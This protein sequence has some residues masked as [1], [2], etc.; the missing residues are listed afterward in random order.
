MTHHDRQSVPADIYT[1][2]Y[3]DAYCQGYAEFRESRGKV[4]PER[5][6]IPFEL[7]QMT[8]GMHILDVGCGRGEILIQSGHRGARAIGID[9]SFAAAETAL[10]AIADIAESDAILVHVGNA[11]CLPYPNDCFDRVFMLDVVEH[12]DRSGLYECL[13]EV[14]RVLRPGGQ[15]IIHTM[16]N[17]WYYRFGYPL[18]RMLQRLRGKRLPANPRDRWGFKEVHV[19]EQSLISLYRVLQ[20]SGFVSRVW[21][22]P[23]H[24]YAEEPNGLVRF[25]MRILVAL[26]PFRLVFCDDLFAVAR[27]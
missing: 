9:Y 20:K 4:I 22:K 25:A 26:Y 23:I 3:Y 7:A 19:N 15:L 8:A 6:R 24:S 12:L 13:H 18:F 1:K 5:L 27:K 11:R 10:Q 16:P 17:I 21:L 2:D 14:R